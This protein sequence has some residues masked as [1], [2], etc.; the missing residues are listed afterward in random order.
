MKLTI[1]RNWLYFLLCLSLFLIY[2]IV[3]YSKM[4]YDAQL[5]TI[6]AFFWSVTIGLLFYSNLRFNN[7]INP[8]TAFSIYIFLFG[9]SIIPI[10]KMQKAYSN[11]TY[12][13]VL[14]S[15]LFFLLPIILDIKIADIKVKVLSLKQR[16][17][18]LHLMLIASC[19]TFLLECINFGFI[20]LF[21]ITSR[22]VY[23]E[24][25]QKLVPFLHYFIVL[26]SYIPCWVYIFRK[27]GIISKCHFRVILIISV[28]I[29][30][31]YLSRQVY[32]LFGIS[33]FVAYCYYH[34][35]K[36]T[37]ILKITFIAL[38]VF[39]LIGYMKFHSTI[40]D[41]FSEYMRLV[42][43][44]ENTEINVVESTF[45]E[46]SS[47]R[48]TALDEILEAKDKLEYW[49]MGIYT[50]RPLISFFLLEKTGVVNR[51]PE[52]DSEVLVTTYAADPYLDYG[53]WGVV[54]LNFVYGAFALG[55]Y[56]NFMQGKAVA[57]ISWSI[58]LFCCLMGMFVNYYNTMLVWL[59]LSFN[60]F[61]LYK[62][63]D[64]T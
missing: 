25:N 24:T 33:L 21:E 20:P 45:V 48:Y 53:F 12:A 52:L 56:Q 30:L 37:S 18:F 8:I 42:A 28:F 23:I 35:V 7:P 51:I 9:Y 19:I 36:L 11:T 39:M 47:K 2:L 6:T 34:K 17:R 61:L 54:L 10:S 41:S 29:L 60:Q 22:D 27:K 32:L 1:N 26:N 62:I 50:F 16:I 5:L 59:G 43:Q 15:L 13:V 58:V 3:R 55:C 31:N 44:I 46:Y 4:G 49:G 64:I 63:E 40:T 38:F 14:L 57:V